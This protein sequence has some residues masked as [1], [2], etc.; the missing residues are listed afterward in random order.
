MLNLTVWFNKTIVQNMC[1]PHH[2][3]GSPFNTQSILVQTSRYSKQQ[4]AWEGLT[5][6]S[7]MCRLAE[8]SMML[9]YSSYNFTLSWNSITR[10]A[11]WAGQN[12]QL[13]SHSC[14][15]GC[16]AEERKQCTEF[17][18]GT[19]PSAGLKLAPE[20]MWMQLHL[21]NNFVAQTAPQERT[22]GSYVTNFCVVCLL[23]TLH[24]CCL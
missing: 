12:R 6:Y 16:G 4:V 8:L 21:E 10:L 13:A 11:S 22:A 2:S 3:S 5:L 9:C 18:P 20:Q 19:F 15:A 1:W 7:K 17:A 14:L 24:V 23:G